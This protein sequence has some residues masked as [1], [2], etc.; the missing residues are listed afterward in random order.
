M[1]AHYAS[2]K[3]AGVSGKQIKELSSYNHSKA[4][5]EKEMATVRFADLVTRGA[6][7][8][9]KETLASLGQFFDDDEIVELALVIC[10]ANMTNRFNETLQV[11]PD[12]G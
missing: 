8:V 4:F 2:A 9:S 3:H 7:A 5:D 1:R 6:A 11:E 12:L 10:F